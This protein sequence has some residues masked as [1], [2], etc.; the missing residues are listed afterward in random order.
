MVQV[1]QVSDTMIKAALMND[2]GHLGAAE[3]GVKP[4][5]A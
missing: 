1:Y 3:Q 4:F 2:F 5:I